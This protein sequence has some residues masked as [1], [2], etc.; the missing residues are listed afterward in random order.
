MQPIYLNA[1]F[2]FFR[3]HEKVRISR[4]AKGEQYFYNDTTIGSYTAED[5]TYNLSRSQDAAEITQAF[6]QTLIAAHENGNEPVTI[7][8]ILTTKAHKFGDETVYQGEIVSDMPM[9]FFDDGQEA[10]FHLPA[11]VSSDDI[12]QS[13]VDVAKKESNFPKAA[14]ITLN[15]HPFA[16]VLQ[17]K[18][19]IH[20]IQSA[21]IKS[22]FKQ[23][24]EVKYLTMSEFQSTYLITE[25]VQGK[26]TPFIRRMTEP[27][28]AKRFSTVNEAYQA[29]QN[30]LDPRTRVYINEEPFVKTA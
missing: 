5:Q 2:A 24:F 3:T 10:I 22:L 27:T 14:H 25:K 18:I 9:A 16:D 11:P 21:Q 15:G 1:L 7:N 6:N 17:G 4:S 29:I 19:K 8:L 28:Q 26:E 13:L 12:V 30:K 20:R 23:L